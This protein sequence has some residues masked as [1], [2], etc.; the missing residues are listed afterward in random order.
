MFGLCSRGESQDMLHNFSV[1]SHIIQRQSVLDR[2][3][4]CLVFYQCPPFLP[5]WASPC[6]RISRD[7]EAPLLTLNQRQARPKVYPVIGDL[8]ETVP[9]LIAC[10]CEDASAAC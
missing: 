4:R 2:R 3:P 9:A 7:P 6:C 8:L 5:R 1:L 10:L